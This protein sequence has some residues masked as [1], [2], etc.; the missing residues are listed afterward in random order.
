MVA[1][2]ALDELTFTSM[3]K[4]LVPRKGILSRERQSAYSARKSGAQVLVDDSLDVSLERFERNELLLAKR[5]DKWWS[6]SS[7]RIPSQQ[8]FIRCLNG[9][10]WVRN[11]N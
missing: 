3:L 1:D 2:V 4:C 6:G 11:S 5:T 10:S 9:A 7:N 8:N